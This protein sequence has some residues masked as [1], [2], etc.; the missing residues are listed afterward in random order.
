M[1][2]WFSPDKG[3]GYGLGDFRSLQHDRGVDAESPRDG[4]ALTPTNVNKPDAP[5][6]CVTEGE[7]W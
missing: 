5:A 6:A 4:V 7:A 1:C 3:D 2:G